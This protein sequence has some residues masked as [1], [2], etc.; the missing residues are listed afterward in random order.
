M[1]RAATHM[2]TAKHHPRCAEHGTDKREE[3]EAITHTLNL[4]ST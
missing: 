1:K 3:P 2:E 4:E